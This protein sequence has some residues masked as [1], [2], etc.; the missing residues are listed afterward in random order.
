MTFFS[1]QREAGTKRKGQLFSV[2]M[3][4]LLLRKDMGQ[5]FTEVPPTSDTGLGGPCEFL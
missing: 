4:L 5:W 1:F 2:N 3:A